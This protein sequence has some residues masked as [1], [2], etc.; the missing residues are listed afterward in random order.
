[1]PGATL[2]IRGECLR[3]LLASRS[4]CASNGASTGASTEYVRLSFASAERISIA[5]ATLTAPLSPL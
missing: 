4:A 2:G 3:P 5:P 1:M